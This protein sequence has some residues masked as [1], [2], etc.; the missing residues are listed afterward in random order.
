MDAGKPAEVLKVESDTARDQAIIDAGFL[1]GWIGEGG[2]RPEPIHEF[3]PSR[4]SWAEGRQ[5]LLAASK[6]IDPRVAE[7]RNIRM[8]NPMEGKRTSLNNCITF[9][10]PPIIDRGWDDDEI[11][12]VWDL[13][14]LDQ[15]GDLAES[16]IK[17]WADA[18]DSGRLVP[19]HGGVLDRLDSIVFNLVLVYYFVI[20]TVP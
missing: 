18:K 7:R 8:A 4:W 5:L 11:A 19:G 15:L 12:T 16:R 9:G 3:E 1:P 6:S 20:W 17:R 10:P 13:K 14:Y 2:L